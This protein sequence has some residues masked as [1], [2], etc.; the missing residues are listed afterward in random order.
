MSFYEC[1]IQFVFSVGNGPKLWT[2]TLLLVS[3]LVSTSKK[4]LAIEGKRL[5][6][7]GERVKGLHSSELL[8][9]SLSPSTYLY[10]LKY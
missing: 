8:A 2:F 6:G 10:I 3:T 9:Y 1:I 4:E 5:T 7:K